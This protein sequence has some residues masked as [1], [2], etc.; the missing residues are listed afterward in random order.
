MKQARILIASPIRQSPHILSLFLQ[1]L[2]RLRQ[3]S[4]TCDYLFVDD[5]EDQQSS[6]LLHQISDAINEEGAA[7]VTIVSGQ[8]QRQTYRRDETTHYWNDEL[9]E[10][11]A[12]WK[13]D[14]LQAARNGQYD[15]LFLVDSDLLLHPNTV[16]SLLASERSIVSSIFWSKWTPNSP[17]LPQVWLRD[18]YWPWQ[19]PPGD[20]EAETAQIRLLEQLRTPGVYEVGGLGACTLIRQEALELP[21]SFRRL[22][23]LSLWG[24]DR[25][26]CVRAVSLGLSLAVDTHYP[27]FH[28]YRDSELI[29]AHQFMRESSPAPASSIRIPEIL[30]RGMRPRLVLSMVAANEEGRYLRDALI[31]HREYIDAAVII[32]DAS[33]DATSDIIHDLL[34]GIPLYYVRNEHSM[35][36]NE[37]ELRRLQWKKTVQLNPEWILNLD[38][39]EYFEDRFTH[40]VRGLIDNISAQ[41]Y[42][43]RLY[44][45]W[46]ETQYREDSFWQAH[47]TY[48]PFLLRYIAGY[49]YRWNEARQHC[50]RF[51]RNLLDMPSILSPLRLKHWGWARESDRR[52]K[53]ARYERLDPGAQFGWK[54]QYDSILDPHPRLVDW[55]EDESVPS[56]LAFPS[57]L[58]I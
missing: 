58:K 57:A 14:F 6:L 34:Q 10:Q 43:F 2:L 48:R 5:N 52:L 44:D 19:H 16:E 39:D 27:A 54:E 26:F 1:S 23:N 30:L 7:R 37:I 51:P 53:A 41:L 15:A 56:Q 46:N 12:I 18:H 3:V 45:F 50:G 47:R 11:I 36:A 42:C 32:D 55:Q 13:D 9:I 35:F 4:W 38:A 33:T 22:P 29:D 21:I 31:R 25:H 17:Q 28:I 24:E 49:P 20:Q 40:E 8:D